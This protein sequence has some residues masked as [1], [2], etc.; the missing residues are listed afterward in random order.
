MKPF[1][2]EQLAPEQVLLRTLVPDEAPQTC[3]TCG[4]EAVQQ[5]SIRG[6]DDNAYFF[7]LGHAI[8]SET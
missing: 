3:G 5:L 1:T 8:A 4:E 7:C 2:I 6:L